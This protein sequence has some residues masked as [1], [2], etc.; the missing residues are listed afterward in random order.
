MRLDELRGLLADRDL[1]TTRR[2][3]VEVY[4]SIPKRVRDE[5]GLD[6]LINGFSAADSGRRPKRAAGLVVDFDELRGEAA[7]L[8]ANAAEG[9]YFRPNRVV[10]KSQRTKWRFVARN[11]IKS[12]VAVRGEHAD[13]AGSLL[14]E[15]Y[16]MLSYA[17][18]IYIFPTQT[19]FTAAGHSQGELLEIVLTKLLF[20][21]EWSRNVRLAVFLVLEC[22]TDHETGRAEL[23]HVLLRACK[24]VDM[25]EAFRA[26]CEFFLQHLSEPSARPYISKKFDMAPREGY[27]RERATYAC[28]ELYLRLSIALHELESGL[29]FF[30][31]HTC[32]QSPDGVLF[33]LLH[34][35]GEHVA[36]Y[37]H[38][39]SSWIEIYDDAVRK[40]IKPHFMLV[41][42][43]EEILAAV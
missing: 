32:G 29:E 38:L 7:V 34:T 40:G 18:G 28:A 24:T 1:E 36:D 26:E 8:L 17:C 20:D 21:G 23:Q 27:Y 33:R 37:P 41:N 6:E 42:L 19:P 43:R 2:L 11:I 3:L 25:R 22:W 16:R 35:I 5:A 12:L 4:R 14:A 30:H 9:L 13:E 39:A 10:P 15:L 31:A